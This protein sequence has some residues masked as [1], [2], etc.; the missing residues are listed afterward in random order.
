MSLDFSLVEVRPTE[1]FSANIT[2]NLG[3]MAAKAGIYKALWRPDEIGAEKAEDI[4]PI[5]EKGIAKMKAAP[6]RFKKY[7]ARNGW[8]TYDVFLPWVEKVL[9]ACKENP[10]SDISVSI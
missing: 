10:T 8:G 4:I 7:D 6:N 1:V 5:L 3:E 2:S 9:E